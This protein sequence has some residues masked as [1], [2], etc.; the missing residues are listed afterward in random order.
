MAKNCKLCKAPLLFSERNGLKTYKHK[1]GY[2][3]DCGCFGSDHP[4]AKKAFQK[5]VNQNKIKF[6]KEVIAKDKQETKT[7][8]E[9]L[10]SVDEYR[11]KYVQPKINLISRL[12]DVFCPCIATNTFGKMNGGHYISVG[13]NRTTCL[14]LH[15]IHIQS[16]QSNHFKSGDTI[17]YEKGIIENYGIEYLEYIKSLHQVP[18]LNLTKEDLIYIKSIAENIIKELKSINESLTK[19]RSPELRI[20][21]RNHY[22]IEL[23]IYPKRFCE[24][25][26]NQ[27]K[28]EL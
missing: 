18:N 3:I 19:K 27:L 16:F 11:A 20:E 24:F 28:N 17:K 13:A 7:K 21:L 26:I 23:G 8:K 5:F 9:N 12:I 25:E 14:H 6:R 1:E 15:N 10:T 22:N 4:E 2:G